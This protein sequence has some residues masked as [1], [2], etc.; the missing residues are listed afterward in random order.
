MAK[1]NSSHSLPVRI[2]ALV[3][4]ILVASGVLMYLVTFIMNLFA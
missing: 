1:N 3:L 4:S 2:L